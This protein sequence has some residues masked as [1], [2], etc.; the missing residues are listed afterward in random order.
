M[1]NFP[2]ESLRELRFDDEVECGEYILN[3]VHVQDLG[4]SRWHNIKRLVFSATHIATGV[5]KLW[6]TPEYR[7]GKTEKQEHEIFEKYMYQNSEVPCTEV[8]EVE[9]TITVIEYYEVG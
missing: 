8:S 1:K 9:K 6:R 3:P 5:A 4:E 2:A 7:V